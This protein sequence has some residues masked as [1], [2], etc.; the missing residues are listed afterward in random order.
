MGHNI[1]L[2]SDDLDYSCSTGG[3][4]NGKVGI[5]VVGSNKPEDPHL[6]AI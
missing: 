3:A 2:G 6:T 5:D 1:K 4:H